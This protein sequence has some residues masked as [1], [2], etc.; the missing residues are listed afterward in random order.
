M[1][2]GI[3]IGEDPKFENEEALIRPVNDKFLLAQFDN[4][5]LGHFSYNW[6]KFPVEDFEIELNDTK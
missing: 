1:K 3:Y 5:N 6:H 2:H 4:V